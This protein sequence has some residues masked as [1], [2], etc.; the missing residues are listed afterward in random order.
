MVLDQR[1]DRTLAIV[2]MVLGLGLAL[3]G[4][5]PAL[6]L[7]MATDSCGVNNCNM[8]LF[9]FGWGLAVFVP[10]FIAVLN[11]VLGTVWLVRGRRASRLVWL[12]FAGQLLAFALGAGL[13]FGAVG[14]L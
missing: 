10:P 3:L 8:A 4:I 5:L 9:S 7:V 11:A 1:G 14:W 2:G 6:I 13:A 12:L